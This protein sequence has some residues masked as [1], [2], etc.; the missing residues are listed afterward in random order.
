MIKRTFYI[1][2]FLLLGSCF[3]KKK[4]SSTTSYVQIPYIMDTSVVANPYKGFVP[5]LE[6]M[7]SLEKTGLTMPVNMVF[8]YFSWAQ[9]EPN[10]PGDYQWAQIEKDFASQ[11]EKNRKIGLRFVMVY[12]QSLSNLD[13]PQWLVNLGVNTK[14]YSIDGF[15]GLAP[16]WD[17]PTLISHHTRV[18]KALAQRYDSNPAIAWF[19]IGSYGFWGEWHVYSNSELAASNGTKSQILKDYTDNFTHLPLVIPFGDLPSTL[20]A[21]NLKHGLRNDCLGT[22]SNN[23]YYY[24]AITSIVPSFWSSP[25]YFPLL[26][27]EFCNGESGALDVI[28]NNYND[29]KNFMVK[30][31]WSFLGPAGSSLVTST[32]ANLDKAKEMYNFMGYN[33]YIKNLSINKTSFNPGEQVSGTLMI[34]NT[35]LNVFPIPWNVYFRID[36]STFLQ[37]IDITQWKPGDNSFSFSFVVPSITNTSNISLEIYI[38]DPNDSTH[39]INFANREQ[40][41]GIMVLLSNFIIKK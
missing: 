27:G 30:T 28:E 7:E 16:D 26:T 19:D 15:S 5:M 9:L 4:H 18:L 25:N 12:P 32:G 21:I 36:T 13:I 11:I 2:M 34:Q 6:S 33:F 31:K 37:N 22:T 1:L 10:A 40:K 20:E 23:N 17:N 39:Y 24:Q 8:H 14:N 3:L 38:S 29:L 41:N 35:G